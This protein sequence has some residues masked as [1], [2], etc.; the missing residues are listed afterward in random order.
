VAPADRGIV[1]GACVRAFNTELDVAPSCSRSPPRWRRAV[2]HPRGPHTL[3]FQI[4]DI[5]PGGTWLLSAIY[6]A[7]G[8]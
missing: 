3:S 5:V 1:N 6:T 2:V 8:D 7:Y 4:L